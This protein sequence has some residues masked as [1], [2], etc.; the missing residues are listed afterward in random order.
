MA[1]IDPQGGDITG[2]NTTTPLYPS[3]THRGSLLPEFNGSQRTGEPID[4]GHK[5]S[6]RKV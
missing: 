1:H 3:V 2:T 4:V 5:V 6:F